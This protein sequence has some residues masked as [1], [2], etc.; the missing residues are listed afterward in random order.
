MALH[1]LAGPRVSTTLL[2]PADEFVYKPLSVREPFAA[3][4]ATR[5]P[6]ARIAADFGA[7]L[8]TDR[9]NGSRRVSTRP[10]RTRARR[11]TTT[12]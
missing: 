7:E 9:W 8:R 4:A 5:Y 11:S 3:A 6:L 1:E 12:C 2:S 10:S